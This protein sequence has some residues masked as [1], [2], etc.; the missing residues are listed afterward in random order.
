MFAMT[1]SF[2][3]AGCEVHTLAIN[4]QK[5]FVNTSTLPEWFSKQTK[6]ETV[7][8]N[9]DLKAVDAFFNL[10]S[11]ASY[12]MVRFDVPQFH[13]K[14]KEI[15]QQQTYDVVQL[16]GLFLSP[17]IATIRANSKALISLRAHNV[18]YLIWER[19]AA[20]TTSFLKKSYL[21]LLARRLKREELQ[22]IQQVD[23]ILPISQVDERTY[24][25]LG[26]KVPML[27]C[28]AGVDEKLLT[29]ETA[30]KEENSLFHLAAMNWQPNVQAVK[31]LMEK[32]WTL[33]H[34]KFPNVNIYLAGKDMPPEFFNLDSSNVRVMGRVEDA[35]TFMLSKNIMLVP[36]LSGSGMRI[37]IIEGMALGKVIIS[38]SIG[39]EGI[40][41]THK[42]DILIAD[43]AA[44]FAAAIEL[45]LKDKL[46]CQNLA[47]NARELVVQKYSNSSIVSKLLDFYR[48]QLLDK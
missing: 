27:V 32:I 2:T 34:A 10:F 37:K 43:T 40:S 48:S 14:L 4:T 36:L 30:E 42:K 5:H 11:N 16:E 12:N 26:V 33:V 8:A 45:A 31:W 38:T 21:N 20:N 24:R 29:L 13:N 22:A 23:C 46:L 19:M 15:L 44:D 3:A 18:E 25:E 1:Q 39:A 9:T 6:L 7:E 28:T 41:Y 17:Y 35:K 47:K